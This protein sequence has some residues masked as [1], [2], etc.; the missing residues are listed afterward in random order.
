MKFNIGDLVTIEPY[1]TVTQVNQSTGRVRI[2][3]DSG[4][5]VYL[6]AS[7]LLPAPQLGPSDEPDYVAPDGSC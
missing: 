1:A 6:D 7:Y 2:T 5:D 4:D 3:F